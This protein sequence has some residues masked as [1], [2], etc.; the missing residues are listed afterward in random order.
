MRFL[1]F[2]DHI[3]HHYC[4][5]TGGC[6]LRE[7]CNELHECDLH[8]FHDSI[9]AIICPGQPHTSTAFRR[10]TLMIPPET[11]YFMREWRPFGVL[12]VRTSDCLATEL[13]QEHINEWYKPYTLRF[14]NWTHTGE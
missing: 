12:V 9:V 8:I 13:L 4:L 10:L 6:L 2:G 1:D 3:A 14:K 11:D 7:D 5:R